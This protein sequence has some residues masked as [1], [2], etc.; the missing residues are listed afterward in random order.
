MLLIGNALVAAIIAT[1][2]WLHLAASREQYRGNAVR[3][4]ENLCHV[5]DAGISG[6]FDKVDL[7]LQD[8]TAAVRN[9]LHRGAAGRRSI[10][11]LLGAH[12]A[13]VP[14]VLS[15]R[16]LDA[17]GDIAYGLGAGTP[18]L[19]FAQRDYFV[20]ARDHPEGGLVVSGP[21]L[22]PVSHRWVLVLA[23]RL[24]L[25]PG[26][27]D[28][29]VTASIAL[30][31]IQQLFAAMKLGPHGAVTLRAQAD[32]ALVARYSPGQ[33]SQGPVGT[34]NVSRELSEVVGRMPGG[35]SYV[36]P[37][38]ID[39]IERVNAF[40]RLD[41][42]PFYVLVGLASDDYLAGWRAEVTGV[43]LLAAL[44]MLGML[45]SSLQIFR[46]LRREQLARGT[47]ERRQAQLRESEE[48]YW[49]V[50]ETSGE[51]ILVA[52]RENRI[53]AVNPAFTRVTGY[54]PEEVLGRDPKLLS[55]GRQDKAF[56]AAMWRSILD[57]GQWRGEIWNRR[58]DG[59]LYPERMTIN[60][61]LDA[62]GQVD[63]R[64]CIFADVT[65]Q[66]RNEDLI[67]RQ[68]NYDA[69]TRLPNRRLF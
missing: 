65:D 7:A 32:L 44:L 39:G 59:S 68:A 60:T 9:E 42:Y 63:R 14:E 67:W 6:M 57:T 47:L 36:A 35:G 24:A 50:F 23:R 37:T 54:T 22:G 30:D 27:F 13:A 56:Y 62:D 51:A 8:T 64:V 43:S 26:G 4:T 45:A 52:D 69:L 1:L 5:L 46:S 10:D 2:A 12:A 31:R 18:E 19:N 55:S 16:V 49:Q 17:R 61:L 11:A 53:V 40:R 3:S 58:R 34:R 38:A 33:G 21:Y 29:V 25:R 15:L 20:A 66:K 28:G 41:R 48:H